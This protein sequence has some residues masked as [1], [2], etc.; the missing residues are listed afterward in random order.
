MYFMSK[1]RLIALAYLFLNREVAFTL[2]FLVLGQ[3]GKLKVKLRS[4]QFLIAHWI[5]NSYRIRSDSD[6]DANF[7]GNG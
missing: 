6:T 3:Q 1:D 2:I 4:F 7:S 5:L